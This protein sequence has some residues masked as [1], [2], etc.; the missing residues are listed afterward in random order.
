IA[1]QRVAVEEQYRARLEIRGVSLDAVLVQ[2]DQDV[3]M[4]A[5]GVDFS[6]RYPQ[7]QP[8]VAAA[9]QRLVAVVRVDVQPEPR[10][11]VCQVVACLV[12]PVARLP[13][14]PDRH[15][16]PVDACH[17]ALLT[18]NPGRPAAGTLPGCCRPNASANL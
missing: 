18:Q 2:S 12:E 11:H 9:D 17:I 3:E 7:P 10:R 13:G 4:V 5:L 8:G 14:Q 6:L 16:P 1:V 15:L